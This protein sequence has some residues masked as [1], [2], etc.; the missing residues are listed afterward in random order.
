MGV[1]RFGNGAPKMLSILRLGVKN[2][3]RRPSLK[4]KDPMKIRLWVDFSS[5][6]PPDGSKEAVCCMP[7]R[8]QT[9]PLA[10]LTRAQGQGPGHLRGFQ[11]TRHRHRLEV[12]MRPSKRLAHRLIFGPQQAA[13]GVHQPPARLEQSGRAVQN[14]LCLLY[15]SDAADE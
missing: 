15:T 4:R 8:P 5:F 11:Q 2:T 3:K 13:G 6:F 7:M 9:Q 14:G 12:R 10:L 1:G